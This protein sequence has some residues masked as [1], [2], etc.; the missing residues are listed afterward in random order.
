[1]PFIASRPVVAE[2]SKALAAQRI[3]LVKLN[4]RY[5]DRHPSLIAAQHTFDATK[6]ELEHAV[7][8]ACEQVSSEYAAAA[9]EYL[10]RKR[11]LEKSGG[12]SHELARV[13]DD[14]RTLERDYAAQKALLEQLMARDRASAAAPAVAEITVS[15][16]GAVN[17]QG[18]VGFAA[19]DKPIALNAIAAAGGFAPNAD[20]NA[21]RVLR[22]EPN[23]TR[24]ALEL[25]EEM[26]MA[27]GSA[28]LVLQRG[29]VIIVPEAR[30]PERKFVTVLGAVNNPGRFTLPPGGMM[31][32]VEVL[33]EAGGHSRMA[34]LKKVK[35]RRVHPGTKATEVAE[36]NVD[37][38]LRGG[39]TTTPD[40]A[41]VQGGDV[42]MVP[43]RIL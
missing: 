18:S 28:N 32:V 23:G 15:V 10:A 34:D 7:V 43:E 11:E 5:R 30:T 38:L 2:L 1:L 12:K 42:V 29:D 14:Y 26:L 6:R 35:V 20:R 36:V 41:F 8:I 13:V 19:A 21:V 9:E 37:A 3:E 25:T 17:A 4:Q 16:I 24:K 22:A 39:P 33:A 27:G 31:S 40:A